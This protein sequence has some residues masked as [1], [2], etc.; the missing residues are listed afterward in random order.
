MLYDHQTF[1]HKSY[2][3]LYLWFVEVSTRDEGVSQL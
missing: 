2:F 3:T 1:T